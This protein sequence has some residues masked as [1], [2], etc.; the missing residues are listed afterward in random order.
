M[1]NDNITITFDTLKAITKYAKQ[2]PF[3]EVAEWITKL[4]PQYGV[5]TPIRMAH[6]L[7]QAC[8]ETDHFRV[9]EEYA[10]GA[11]YEGRKDLGNTQQ[12]DGKRYKG[13]GIFQ[14]TGRAN[15]A[16]ASK[17]L[18]EDFVAHP[19][20]LCHPAFAVESAL[21]YWRD[22][23]LSVLADHDDCTAITR[24][25]NGGFNGLQDREWHLRAAKEVLGL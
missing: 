4:A 16:A 22:K 17:D 8:H 18:N 13:R 14:T 23:K 20:E 24:R 3:A 6:F 25:I 7:S 15:Y 19:E 10:S 1:E 9:L 21:L 11:A 2:E 12:G 5:D